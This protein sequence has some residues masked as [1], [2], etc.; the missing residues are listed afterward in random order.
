M[1]ISDV[2]TG[3]FGAGCEALFR[4]TVFQGQ[5]GQSRESK[6]S[7]REEL[8]YLDRDIFFLFFTPQARG[9]KSLYFPVC[10]MLDTERETRPELDIYKNVNRKRNDV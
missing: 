6:G 5:C 3:G 8:I 2:K 4:P 9:G 10:L 7:F 1:G